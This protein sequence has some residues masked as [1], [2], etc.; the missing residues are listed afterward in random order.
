MLSG[1]RDHLPVSAERLKAAQGKPCLGVTDADQKVK[2][3][4][5]FFNF[6]QN[7]VMVILKRHQMQLVARKLPVHTIPQIHEGLCRV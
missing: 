5:Q 3:F 1:D 4:S 6:R 2:F 7:A